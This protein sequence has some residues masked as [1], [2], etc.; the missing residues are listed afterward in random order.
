MSKKARLPTVVFVYVTI[1]WFKVRFYTLL[2]TSKDK[3]KVTRG[4][5]FDFKMITR[6]YAEFKYTCSCLTLTYLT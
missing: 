1:D 4:N 3:A 6:L 5:A 2:Y